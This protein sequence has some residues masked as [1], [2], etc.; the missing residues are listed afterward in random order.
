MTLDRKNTLLLIDSHAL[1]YRAYYAFPPSL[2]SKNGEPTNA[3]YGFT[4]LLI[5][6]LSKFKPTNVVAV[7]DSKGPTIRSTEYNQYKSNRKEAEDLFVV[8]LPRVEEVIEAFGIP[9]LKING[10]EADDLIATIDAKHSGEWANTIVVTGDRDLFQLVD[11]DTFVYLAGGSFSQSK[12]YDAE[13]VLEKMGVTPEKIID[14]KGLSGDASDNI[15]GVRGIG[16]KSAIDLIN[17]FGTLEGIYEHIEEVKPRYKQKLIENQEIALV[18]KKLATVD[19]DAP[20]TFDLSQSVLTSLNMGKINKVFEEL[21]FNSLKNRLKSL[22]EVY[23][24]EGTNV[25]LFEDE[26]K[27]DQKN[28]LEVIEWQ[29]EGINQTSIYFLSKVDSSA[30]PLNYRIEELYFIGEKDDGKIY[31]VSIDFIEEFFKFALRKNLITFDSKKLL[32]VAQ[33]LNTEIIYKDLFDVGISGFITSFGESGYSLKGIFEKYNLKFSEDDKEN[34]QN[35]K[36]LHRQL[37]Y[38]LANNENLKSLAQLEKDILPL[39]VEMERAGIILDKTVL[40]EYEIKLK[41]EIEELKTEIY[42]NVGHEFNI[43]S[44]KQLGEVL[45]RE[46]ALPTGRKTKGGAYSTNESELN[47]L[48]GVDPIIDFL[49]KYRELEKL[50]STYIKA[51]PEYIDNTT[52][53]IHAVFD[54]FGAVS[55]RFSSKN[56]N[57]QNIPKGEVGGIDIR[58]AFIAD[59]NSIFVSFDYSQQE[60]RILAALSN[61]E[62]MIKSF[63]SDSD[64]H[65]LTASEIFGVPINEINSYQ[66][67]VGKTVNFSVIYGISPFALSERLRIPRGDGAMFIQKYFD[68]YKNVK[69]YLDNTIISARD[70]GYT[71]TIL[72]RRRVNPNI[73]SLNFNLRNAAERELFNFII[74][75]SAADVMKLSMKN[76]LNVMPKYPSAKLLLQIHDEFLFEY[77]FESLKDPDEERNFKD[78]TKEIYDIMILSHDIGVKYQVEVST[79]KNWGEMETIKVNN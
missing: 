69:K 61:E 32:H 21:N 26:P 53:R 36:N 7:M 44:P 37:V 41:S 52:G 75:G 65:K 19:R 6:V 49:L 46:K 43:K 29:G 16:P 62:E 4:S 55:G 2:K 42:K 20:I 47:K 40:S 28:E 70:Q 54:Q 13:G 17:E 15:P 76:F 68:K 18:S 11:S 45:F 58:K 60:L 14:Y 66:R 63:N 22:T 1:I 10:Y 33:N 72:G 23:P 57:L 24:P 12:L 59:Q 25:S 78:F 50:M 31:H 35:L 77:N 8:Q 67:G 64:I 56:P 3:V 79:G 27:E 9:L 74:Q 73:N 5:D 48:V 38:G 51:L 39:V 30:N 71:E 34:L